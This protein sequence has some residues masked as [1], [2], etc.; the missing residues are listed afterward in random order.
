MLLDNY[1]FWGRV[2]K[3]KGD[4]VLVTD[5]PIA[6]ADMG[7]FLPVDAHQFQKATMLDQIARG[8]VV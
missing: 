6:I 5:P 7:F 3:S 1:F 8:S 4:E 2:K